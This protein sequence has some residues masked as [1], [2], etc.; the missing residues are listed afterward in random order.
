M[1]YKLSSCLTLQFSSANQIYL[2]S[3]LQIS[4]IIE[5][6][7]KER[8]FWCHIYTFH[9]VICAVCLSRYLPW[10]N[11]KKILLAKNA[12]ICTSSLTKFCKRTRRKTHKN[13]T[14]D[15]TLYNL[16]VSPCFDDTIIAQLVPTNTQRDQFVN[17]VLIE[18]FQ[19]CILRTK[20]NI[21]REMELFQLFCMHLLYVNRFFCR[22]TWFT[23]QKRFLCVR[24]TN[25][26][27][28]IWLL[29]FVLMFASFSFSLTFIWLGLILGISENTTAHTHT[30]DSFWI[31][32]T[33]I[34][35]FCAATNMNTYK[36]HVMTFY[37]DVV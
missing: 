24:R 27:I 16:F 30:Q 35:L 2:L 13:T 10:K 36:S 4:I 26:R 12:C 23:T 25:T 22:F 17:Y 37:S 3:A 7:I 14:S 21:I 31:G 8:G 6:N 29:V 20:R 9:R 11:P 19:F 34:R 33:F 28:I 5:K 32:N 15:V 1:H 18:N